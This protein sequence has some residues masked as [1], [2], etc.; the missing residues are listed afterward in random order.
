MDLQKH[1]PP[2]RFKKKRGQHFLTDKNVLKKIVSAARITK[3]D[4]VLEIGAG[5][6]LL[7]EFL[8]LSAGHVYAVEIEKK[9]LDTLREKF[10]GAA[11]VQ[12]I[13]GDFL[14]MKI[15]NI[16]K[17]TK[18]LKV[19]ANI[20]YSIT[21]PI[22]EKLLLHRRFFHEIVLTVQKEVADRICAS[23]GNKTYGSLTLFVRYYCV[24]EKLFNISP[25]CF[26]PPPDVVS[27]CVRLAVREE[28]PAGVSDE[29]F[30]FR[31]IASAF[32]QRRKTL[33]NAL[34][35]LPAHREEILRAL[36]ACRLPDTARAEQLSME[37][38]AQLSGALKSPLP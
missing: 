3:E 13:E 23:H 26:F 38:F 6:G 7:T 37:Q 5:T 11:S 19:V 30:F 29:R 36:K 35:T 1:A 24:P 31:V 17:E 4:A 20:P 34:R 28:L 14:K 8:S 12:I 2:V 25:T 18:K 33:V 16:F 9:F 22:L 32:Q 27:A 21:A 10:S 15:D